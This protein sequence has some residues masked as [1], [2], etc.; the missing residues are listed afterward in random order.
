M[1]KGTEVSPE[2]NFSYVVK[3]G[4]CSLES[5]QKFWNFFP[6]QNLNFYEISCAGCHQNLSL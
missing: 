4:Q 6:S 5:L 3:G 2:E 1:F